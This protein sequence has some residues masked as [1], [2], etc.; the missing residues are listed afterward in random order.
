MTVRMLAAAERDSIIDGFFASP[1]QQLGLT[2]STSRKWV[3][4]TKPPAR[5]VFEFKLLKGASFIASWGFSL[6][7]VP[8]FSGGNPRWHRSDKLAMLDIFISPKTLPEGCSLFGVDHLSENL[9]SLLPN[10]T[11]T[12]KRDWARGATWS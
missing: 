2:K 7:F 3:D 12:A 1:L 10:S 6:D 4:G 11:A 9:K 5:R 8:H